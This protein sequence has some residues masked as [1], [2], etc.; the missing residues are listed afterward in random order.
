MKQKSFA[1]RI[2]V[3]FL[4]K[5]NHLQPQLLRVKLL[6]FR[7]GSHQLTL[8]VKGTETACIDIVVKTG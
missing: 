8:N 2:F 3:C 7:I 6:V 1:A 5:K 4:I